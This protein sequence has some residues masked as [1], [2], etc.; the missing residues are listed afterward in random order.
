MLENFHQRYLLQ[1]RYS[2]RKRVNTTKTWPT[3]F[4]AKKIDI[5]Y[6]NSLHFSP[7]FSSLHANLRTFT[8]L[9]Q[10]FV[11]SRV[12]RSFCF[13]RSLF[14]FY[15]WRCSQWR[16]R[17]NNSSSR[18]RRIRCRKNVPHGLVKYH[19]QGERDLGKPSYILKSDW[20][21]FE[22]PA[23]SWT[24]TSRKT[25]LHITYFTPSSLLILFCWEICSIFMI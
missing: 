2:E 24:V 13:H 12:F 11:R 17:G 18:G 14:R 25:G 21:I 9:M 23:P 15:W 5:S 7:V 16:R 8:L 1:G 10:F 22:L 4:S 3:I 20:S 6:F 19:V